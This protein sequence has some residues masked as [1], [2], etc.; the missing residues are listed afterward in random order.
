ML[1]HPYSYYNLENVL[2]TL[3]NRSVPAPASRYS[4]SNSAN[5]SPS[6][7]AAKP[8]NFQ[9][10]SICGGKGAFTVRVLPSG[11]VSE[12]ERAWRCSLRPCSSPASTEAAPPYFPP[13]R[14]GVPSSADQ[15]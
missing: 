10:A 3:L 13:P 6:V 7:S 12:I 1:A 8:K 4:S 11:R 2:L 5:G 14:I 9:V 15:K